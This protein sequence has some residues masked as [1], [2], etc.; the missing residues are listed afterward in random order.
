MHQVII[1]ALRNTKLPQPMK[2]RFVRSS[3]APLAPAVAVAAELE[4]LF[5]ALVLQA[6]GMTEASHQIACNP[7][8]PGRTKPGS[9]GLPTGTEIRIV[10]EGGRLMSRGQRGEVCIAGPGVFGGY[11]GTRRRTG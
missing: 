5:G 11:A 2:L 6:Y 4:A 3:S 9:V 7:L 10:G 1:A 8:P